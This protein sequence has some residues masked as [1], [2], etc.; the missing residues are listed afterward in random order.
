MPTAIKI[1]EI[2]QTIAAIALMAMVG[3]WIV[4]LLA[5]ERRQTN[6]FYQILE[7]VGRPFVRLAAFITPKMVPARHH[8]FVAFCLLAT[9]YVVAT[10]LRI[11][12]CVQIGVKA[13][14][15]S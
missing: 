7:I 2:V 11:Q 14:L 3:Q 9:I 1:A 4:G 6:F 10:V 15:P 8:A 12:M 5:G 13:C